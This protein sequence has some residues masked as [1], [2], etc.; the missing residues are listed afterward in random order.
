VLIGNAAVSALFLASYSLFRPTTGHW[1]IF[2]A[3]LAGGF[4]RSLE[5]TGINTLA[6][7][8]VPPALMSRATSFQSMAQQLSVSVGVGTGALL[9]H[10][11]LTITGHG[12]LAADDFYPAFLA[13]A[14]ISTT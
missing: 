9:V 14:A 3:L 10:V 6:F 7:A 12:A 2:V 4:F 1:L 5:F 11:T 13:V 8:D